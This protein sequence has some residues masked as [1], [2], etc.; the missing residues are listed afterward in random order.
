MF[1]RTT[2]DF[3]AMYDNGIRVAVEPSF[4][5]GSTRRYAGTFWDY[6]Q[7]ILDFET[8]RARRFGI[9][10][11]A[12]ISVN[13][14]E[15]ENLALAEEVLDGIEPYLQH[16]RCVAIGEIGF[17]LI[18][19]NEEKVFLR[20]LEIAKASRM[21]VL[22]HTPHDTPTVSK[23]VGLE[24]TLAILRELN[25][26]ND[27]I[28]V[29]HNTENTMDLTRKAGVWAGLTVYPYSKLNPERVGS[30]LEK[31]GIERTWVDSSADWG[32]S[33][34]TSLAKV[35]KHL[36]T[37]GFSQ[38]QI[39]KLLRDNPLEFYRQSD[40]FKPNLDLPYTHPSV[41]QR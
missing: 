9:D 35:A 30:I 1:S 2:D 8:I 27:R 39:E 14:K 7:L 5:L 10:H 37:N 12:C 41:Y 16:E 36:Q 6:Y 24:R 28:I 11:Y 33:D 19:P 31:W 34:P 15:A 3:Q 13:P 4:W 23:R 26:D 21:L 32:S 25:Y 29:D 20:Q 38:E 40:K 18:T 17:N 22:I